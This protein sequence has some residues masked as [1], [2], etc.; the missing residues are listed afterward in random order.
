[1]PAYKAQQVIAEAINSVL[2]QTYPNFELIIIDD[3]SPDQ[4][5]NIVED[6]IAKD[7]R[8]RLIKKEKNQGVAAARNTGLDYAR[9]DYVAFLDSD[10]KWADNKLALQM[11][12]FK[13]SNVDVIFGA[14]YRFNSKGI[15]N[16]VNVPSYIE[17]HNLLKGNCIGNLTGIYNFKKF[18]N[19]RQKKVGHEDYLFWLEIF[20]SNPNVK[21]IGI[22]EPI[23]YYRV[24]ENGNNLSANKF[25]AAGWT[26]TIFRKYLQ[27]N[28]IKSFFYFSFYIIFN[29]KFYK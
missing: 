5:V 10:D 15:I 9:G 13:E 6:Y 12:I 23:A 21:G 29:K 3:F 11:K 24:A 4:T 1:M 19:I 17:K 22:Q 14:Y 28:L 8:I 26:W 7:K 27:L 2:V 20:H 16:L 18:P 25:K